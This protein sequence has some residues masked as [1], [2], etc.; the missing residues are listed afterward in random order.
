M[1]MGTVT[2]LPPKKD[3]IMSMGTATPLP[4]DARKEMIKL[5]A[6]ARMTDV[7]LLNARTALLSAELALSSETRSLSEMDGA[8]AINKKKDGRFTSIL[9]TYLN[10][11]ALVG[12]LER[13]R[14][15]QRIRLG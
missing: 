10:K 11:K 14:E 2:P 12:M 6:E 4:T 15:T 5:R 13:E 7:L 3:E 9:Q 1:S 8:K